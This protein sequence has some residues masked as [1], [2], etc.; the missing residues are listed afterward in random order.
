MS[1]FCQR[2]NSC[3]KCLVYRGWNPV[4]M[5]TTRQLSTTLPLQRVKRKQSAYQPIVPPFYSYGSTHRLMRGKSLQ[6]ENNYGPLV[7][8]PDYTYLDGRP[9]PLTPEQRQK[10]Q[11]RREM[12]EQVM[13]Y[14]QEI[15]TV[16]RY[17]IE[18][19]QKV[20][21]V[22]RHLQSRKLKPKS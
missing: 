9:T 4:M 13:Q 14:M 16:K 22:E 12:A 20:L 10:K 17:A 18:K 21:D 1:A 6:P 19:K 8:L 7:D 11:E 15:D 2:A 5:G 3:W